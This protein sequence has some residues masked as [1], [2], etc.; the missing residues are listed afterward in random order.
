MLG[1]IPTN[2]LAADDFSKPWMVRPV[3]KV[4]TNLLRMLNTVLRL[5]PSLSATSGA[6]PLN[7]AGST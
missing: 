4:L 7:G 6:L 5:T 1:R 2:K 3:R